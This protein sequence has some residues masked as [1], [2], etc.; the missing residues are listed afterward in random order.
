MMAMNPSQGGMLDRGTASYETVGQRG[1]KICFMQFF[2]DLK[3][4]NRNSNENCV[5]E[6]NGPMLV[7]YVGLLDSHEGDSHYFQQQEDRFVDVANWKRWFL[8]M[9]LQETVGYMKANVCLEHY[10]I[11]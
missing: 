7:D 10:G 1:E 4:L 5:S 3:K 8:S 11:I 2:L 6:G 9:N